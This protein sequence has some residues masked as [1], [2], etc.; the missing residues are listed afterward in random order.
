MA[1]SNAFS[2]KQGYFSNT[3]PLYYLDTPKGITYQPDVYALA[4]FLAERS[5]VHTILDI[6]SGNGKKL[7]S[8]AEKYQVIAVDFGANRQL[9]KESVPQAR[10]IEAD[11]EKALPSLEDIDL[12]NTLVIVADVVEHIVNPDAFLQW[13]AAISRQCSWLLMS[14][15]DR[16]CCRG[17]GDYG[18]PANPCHVREWSIDEFSALLQRYEF[19]PAMLG[20]TVNTDHHL[21]KTTILAVMGKTNYALTQHTISALAIINVYNEEDCLEEVVRHVLDQGLDLQIVDNWSTDSSWSIAQALQADF[22]DRIFLKRFPENAPCQYYEWTRLLQHSAQLAAT[23]TY[24]WIMHYDADEIRESPWSNVRLK[25]AIAFIDE[26]GYNAIDFTVLDFRPVQPD[27]QPEGK[28]IERLPFFEFG[29]RSGH[30]CQVKAW[31]NHKGFPV[32]LAHSGGHSADFEGRKIYPLKFLNRHYSL[33]SQ[34]QARK[35]IM[36]DRQTRFSPLEKNEKGW[37]TQY[38]GF[39]E[40][41]D[42]LW[43]RHQLDGT[44]HAMQFGMEF[45]VER[46]SGIGIN[47]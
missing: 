36:Q 2:I 31:K 11:L 14:T 24:D 27:P 4:S 7:T 18:P 20:Y 35:K 47:R 16:V 45:L 10:F 32:E 39:N 8:F 19:S 22:P 25:E 23:T 38:D 46:I 44:F 13:L 41:S 34:S 29:R 43:E 40:T 1:I 15:P 28:L 5:G 37:H 42:F 3:N 12:A 33:R 6:G 9:I 26:L 17:V 30:F 21:Q